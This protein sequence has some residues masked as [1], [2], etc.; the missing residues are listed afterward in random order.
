MRCLFRTF[1]VH[2]VCFFASAVGSLD[3]QGAKASIE[4]DVIALETFQQRVL[5]HH[6]ELA[7]IRNDQAQARQQVTAAKGA[8]DPKLS[9]S[10]TNKRLKSEPYYAFTDVALS[11]P[12]YIGADF[13]LGFERGVGSKINP[14]RETSS[15]GLLTLGVS[16]PLGRNLI[17]DERRTLITRARAL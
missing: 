15:G 10:L 1:A 6:P 2:V 9:A 17:T 13:K 16:I 14:E 4:R 8:F 3:A 5:A 11:V 12:T 7:Q